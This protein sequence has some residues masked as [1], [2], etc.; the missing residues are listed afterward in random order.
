VTDA[1]L[2]RLL[3]WTTGVAAAALPVAW[4]VDAPVGVL[5][6]LI[7]AV[8]CSLSFRV[9]AGISEGHGERPFR[10]RRGA[11]S[12]GSRPPGPYRRVRDAVA[13]RIASLLDGREG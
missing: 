11:A 6:G 2:R 3:A 8:G 13:A 5:G 7:A 9:A 10:P 1:G 4:L 12:G